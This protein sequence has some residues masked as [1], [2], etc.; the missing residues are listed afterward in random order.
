ML[1]QLRLLA[2]EE[3]KIK[4]LDLRPLI[5][6]ETLLAKGSTLREIIISHSTTLKVVEINNT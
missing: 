6:L 3:S 2:V 4:S 5:F 1:S